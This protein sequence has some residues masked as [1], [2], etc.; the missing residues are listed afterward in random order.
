MRADGHRRIYTLSSYF[1]E[2]LGEKCYKI[3]I[4]AGL[5]CPNRDGTAG[6]GGCTFCSAGGSGDFAVNRQTGTIKDQINAGLSLFGD[7]QTGNRFIAYFQAYTNTYGPLPYLEQLYTEALDCPELCGISIAT[8]PDCLGS[9]VMTLL[10]KLKSAYPDKSIWIELGL[11]TMHEQT[12]ALIRRG[13]P[14]SVFETACRSL[15]ELS[16]PVILHLILGLPGETPEL[17]YDTI[18]YVGRLR[19]FG[20]KLQLLHILKGTS[21]GEE[22]LADPD[23]LHILSMEEYIDILIHCIELLPHDT[24][25]HR[26]TGDGPRALLLAPL[27]SLNKKQVLGTLQHTM[28][29]RNAYQGRLTH[30]T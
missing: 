5:T 9:D 28:K 7:K 19:P 21:L 4:D 23:R 3:A 15:E 16:I 29:I 2:T 11:Q 30:D 22:Y 25:I 24:V 14:L 27:W 26:V 20:V 13:Y 18:R 1:K 12:A 17:M 6:N 8:R 10:E